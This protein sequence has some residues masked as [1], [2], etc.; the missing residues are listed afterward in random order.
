MDKVGIPAQQPPEFPG[1]ILH[2]LRWGGAMLK[3]AN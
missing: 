1:S 2:W 3:N